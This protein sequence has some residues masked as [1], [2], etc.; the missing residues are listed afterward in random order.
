MYKIEDDSTKKVLKVTT[1]GMFKKDE[2]INFINEFE[3]KIKTI[4]TKQYTLIIDAKE[5]KPSSTDVIP[6]QEKAIKLYVDTP[7]AKRYSI[8]MDSIITTQQIKRL[9]KNELLENFTFVNSIQEAL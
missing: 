5:Q 3:K 8:V 2:A 9:G 1:A 6:L 7:F 4:D